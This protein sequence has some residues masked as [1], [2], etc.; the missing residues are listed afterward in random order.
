VLRCT[1]IAGVVYPG[2]SI[3]VCTRFASVLQ[4]SYT[5]S[6]GA[7]GRPVGANGSERRDCAN[8]AII[9]LVFFWFSLLITGKGPRVIST[10]LQVAT[11]V[12]KVFTVK[13]GFVF[14]TSKFSR[15]MRGNETKCNGV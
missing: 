11:F 2:H 4:T 9:L 5:Q 8:E 6:A 12:L 7:G 14:T 3:D 13:V 10:F 1:Y 15:A